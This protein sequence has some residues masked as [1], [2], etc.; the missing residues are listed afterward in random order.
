MSKQTL[1]ILAV[2]LACS[3]G[4]LAIV[5]V[6]TNAPRRFDDRAPLAAPAAGKAAPAPSTTTKPV[7]AAPK[8]GGTLKTTVVVGKQGSG[9][10]AAS[11]PSNTQTL[12]T[13]VRVR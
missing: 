13:T 2:A 1:T 4:V 5:T 12:H 10:Q 11:T 6:S 3:M 7:S 8:T 9:V